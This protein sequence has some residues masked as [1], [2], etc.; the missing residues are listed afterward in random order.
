M[1]QL[2]EGAEGAK[3]EGNGEPRELP[4]Y[5]SARRDGRK[6]AMEIVYIRNILNLM[7]LWYID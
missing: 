2:A 1:R 7:F 4:P 3:V 5:V 6:Y